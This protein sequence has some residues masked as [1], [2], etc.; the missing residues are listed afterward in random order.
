[1]V[2]VCVAL[3]VCVKMSEATVREIWKEGGHPYKDNSCD[4]LLVL[5]SAAV[6][7]VSP[8]LPSPLA[9]RHN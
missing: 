4:L 1:M 2:S 9:G 6:W 5:I 8:R 3:Q 7:W